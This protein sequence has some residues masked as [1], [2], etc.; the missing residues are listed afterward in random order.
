MVLYLGKILIIFMNVIIF[1]VARAF[2]CSYNCILLHTYDMAE[3]RIKC[4]KLYPLLS[5][6]IVF[7]V[8][9]TLHEMKCVKEMVLLSTVL[10]YLA[11]SVYVQGTVA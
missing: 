8:A 3:I 5:F 6:Q 11:D 10:L 4:N 7:C 1:A 9:V 2:S